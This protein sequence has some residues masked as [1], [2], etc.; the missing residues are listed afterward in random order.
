MMVAT[1]GKVKPK[2]LKWTHDLYARL[3]PNVTD[4]RGRTFVVLNPISKI[5]LADAREYSTVWWATESMRR[6]KVPSGQSYQSLKDSQTNEIVDFLI[7]LKGTCLEMSPAFWIC[8]YEDVHVDRNL[9]L[10]SFESN[11]VI[12]PEL[13]RN[14]TLKLRSR[15]PEVETGMTEKL[16]FNAVLLH[17]AGHHYMFGNFDP[18]KL[19]Q[20]RELLDLN[21]CEGFASWFAY[22]LATK[23]ERYLLAES[24]L[25]MQ[26]PYRY[27]LVLKPYQ[28]TDLLECF[29]KNAD[30]LAGLRTFIGIAGWRILLSSGGI[31]ANERIQG[32][33]LM[34]FS[35]EGGIVV[36]GELI[37]RIVPLPR[38]YIITP[39]IEYLSG[40]CPRGSMIFANEIVEHPDYGMLPENIVVIPKD[41]LDLAKAI[42]LHISKQD[43]S[44]IR[45]ILS[46]IRGAGYSVS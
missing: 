36:A 32:G 5:L 37:E 24:A 1:V 30:Y 7:R 22:N 40:R 42:G 17:E 18:A 26:E 8:P 21:L 27:Y 9:T 13:I 43:D 44:R 19:V 46:E 10:H 29:L 45:G 31:Y 33:V 25:T 12:C 20:V 16:L 28:M 4:E 34:D 39:K 23:E 14:E 38:G 41:R 3:G 2:Y 15:V 11:I 6:G 35:V